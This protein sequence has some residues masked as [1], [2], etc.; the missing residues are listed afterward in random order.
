MVL[1]HRV[2]V[3]G[4]EVMVFDPTN[5]VMAFNALDGIER[6]MRKEEDIVGIATKSPNRC[7]K[8]SRSSLSRTT[9]P[10]EVEERSISVA[11]RWMRRRRSIVLE[12][13]GFGD[14]AE[15]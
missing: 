13:L 7:A 12:V 10:F 8:T 11:T 5:P 14:K 1:E 3:L 4:G 2:H 6:S 9:V 15:A